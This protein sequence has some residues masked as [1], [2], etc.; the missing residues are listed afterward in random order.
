MKQCATCLEYQ[1]TLPHEKTIPYEVL[2]KPWGV[3][4]A[5]TFS[6]NNHMLFYIVDYYS[7][8]PIK[9]KAD[10]LSADNLIRAATIVF[11]KF[12]LPKK[13]I[14]NAG[15]N[16]ILDEFKQFCRQM[17]ID[18]AIT[19]LYHHQSSRQ[20]EVCIKLVKSTKEIKNIL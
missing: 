2:H 13:I 7:K 16:F 19:S 1:Q 12:G 10:G 14:P 4:S 3:V 5:D 11:T 20:V 15:I 6:I 9:K 8:L 18:Q 17:S